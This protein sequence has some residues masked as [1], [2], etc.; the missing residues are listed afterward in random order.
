MVIDRKKTIIVDFKNNSNK[1]ISGKLLTYEISG[2]AC[3]LVDNTRIWIPFSRLTEKSKNKIFKSRTLIQNETK[4][5]LLN[6]PAVCIMITLFVII[7]Y[8]L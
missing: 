5:I 4:N 7:I 3:V 6:D 8:S 2:E 1:Q